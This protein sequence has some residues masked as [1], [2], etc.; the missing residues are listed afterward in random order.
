MKNLLKGCQQGTNALKWIP[1]LVAD[2]SLYY[3]E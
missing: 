3:K 1:N 2:A